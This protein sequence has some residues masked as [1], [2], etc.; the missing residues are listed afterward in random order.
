MGEAAKHRDGGAIERRLEMRPV[1]LV[2]EARRRPAA[3]VGDAVVDRDD[4]VAVD[5]VSN[6]P[7][8]QHRH[9]HPE[10]SGSLSI[11]IAPSVK[12]VTSRARLR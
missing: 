1:G 3:R 5:G 9:R 10:T 11:R 7:G 4:G 8:S 2:T 12:D 6:S